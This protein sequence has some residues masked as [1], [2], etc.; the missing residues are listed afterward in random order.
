MLPTAITYDYYWRVCATIGPLSPHHCS[1]SQIK[2]V[3]AFNRGE[4]PHHLR[5]N[6]RCHTGR[7]RGGRSD[8]SDQGAQVHLFGRRRLAVGH[9]PLALRERRFAAA[10]DRSTGVYVLHD[11]PPDKGGLRLGEWPAWPRPV[12][13]R[14]AAIAAAVAA[15]PAREGAVAAVTT[16]RPAVA[17]AST[18]SPRCTRHPSAQPTLSTRLAAAAARPVRCDADRRPARRVRPAHVRSH[19][20]GGHRYDMGGLLHSCGQGRHRCRHDRCIIPPGH[21]RAELP[22]THHSAKAA[23]T[24][25]ITMAYP[26]HTSSSDQDV[27]VEG[28]G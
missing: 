11:C 8:E 22:V 12:S 6:R 27:E 24:R 28:R 3:A 20:C 1:A 10:G 23:P 7:V 4:E 26:S 16:A 15:R 5:G 17:A 14:P 9:L 13:S 18:S 25:A 21:L 19:S 2:S